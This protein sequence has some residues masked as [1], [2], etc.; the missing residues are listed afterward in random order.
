MFTKDSAGEVIIKTGTN[1]AKVKFEEE[2]NNEPLVNVTLI[3][4][5]S[6]SQ[7]QKILDEGYA[8]AVTDKA[9][10]GFTIILNKKASE[11]IEIN[12]SAV[13]TK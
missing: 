13:E 7:R 12:W 2:F 8:I 3:V 10:S 4:R 5:G 1:I 6:G 9:P 11:D